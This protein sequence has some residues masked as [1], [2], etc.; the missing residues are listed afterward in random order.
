M[1]IKVLSK[2][3]RE[4]EIEIG[5]EGHTF[6]N[7]L[8]SALLQDKRVE[9]ATYDIEHPLISDPILYVR[10]DGSDPVEVLR[11]AAS[12]VSKQLDEFKKKFLT[13]TQRDS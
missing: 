9:A 2:S 4:I 8:K 13:A 12:Q 6:L 3:E 10:T 7:L 1:E 5:G 11:D